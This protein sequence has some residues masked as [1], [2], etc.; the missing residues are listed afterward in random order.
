[1]KNRNKF[2]FW[3]EEGRKK[4]A[5]VSF[6]SILLIFEYLIPE[7]TSIIKTRRL[8]NI[9]LYI[10]GDFHPLGKKSYFPSF[11]HPNSK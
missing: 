6:S 5:L 10:P 8:L 11:F 9:H 2:R 4:L 3:D 1:M 7:V